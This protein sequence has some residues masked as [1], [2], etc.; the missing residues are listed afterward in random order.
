[1]FS[2]N[3]HLLFIDEKII[4]FSDSRNILLVL[5]IKLYTKLDNK[6]IKINM[7]IVYNEYDCNLFL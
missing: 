5:L 4:L 7:Y 6:Q 3:L 2:W 1:M